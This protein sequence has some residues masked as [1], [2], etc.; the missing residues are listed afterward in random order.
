MQKRQL[1][2]S[3]IEILMVLALLGTLYFLAIPAFTQFL[4]RQDREVTLDRLRT[5]I[6]FAKSEAAKQ[7]KMITLCGSENQQTCAKNNWNHGFI[8]Y[9]EEEVKKWLPEGVFP[10]EG[11]KYGTLRFKAFGGDFHTLHIGP[12]GTTINNGTFVYC[13]KDKNAK[14]ARALIINQFGRV[15]LSTENSEGDPLYCL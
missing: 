10:F 12:N 6:Q 9:T 3:F 11:P 7:G 5:A 13:P 15:Y 2:I 14:E 8:L 4:M 1:G